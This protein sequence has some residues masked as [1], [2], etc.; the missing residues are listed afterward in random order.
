MN[1]IE[2]HPW[3]P[4]QEVLDACAAAGVH[5]MAYSPL[6]STGS[7]LA[8]VPIIVELAKKKGVTPAAILLSLHGKLILPPFSP[9]AFLYL[10]TPSNLFTERGRGK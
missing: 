6:G 9:S 2:N 1:Q 5:V 8:E 4:Q 3:L 7:P 10:Y